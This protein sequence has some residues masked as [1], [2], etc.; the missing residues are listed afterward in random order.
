MSQYENKV[1]YQIF[2]RNYKN[3]GTFA[4]IIADLER[5]K[6]I[7]TDI[8]YLMPINEIGIKNRKGT[9]GSPYA[10][11]DY[12]SISKDLGTLNLMMLNNIRNG[13]IL[14]I[15]TKQ[16][17]REAKRNAKELI[18]EYK[19]MIDINNDEENNIDPGGFLK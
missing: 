9:Y 1:I 13:A 6:D 14:S 19:K 10:S 11:K 15:T 7:G 17:Q 12:F 4:E 18:E 16:A 5:I 3:N 8:I 2:P